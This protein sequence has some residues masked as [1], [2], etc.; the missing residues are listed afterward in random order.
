MLFDGFPREVYEAKMLDKF[1]KVSH[2]FVM[3][4]PEELIIKRLSSRYECYCGMTYNLT[5]KKPRHDLM[6]DKCGRKLY[7]REDDKPGLIRKRINIYKRETLPVVLH[8]KK[9]SKT[10]VIGINGAREIRDVFND[11][12]KVLE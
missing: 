8:Y 12:K 10:K 5:S 9:N 1:I 2:V 3:K 7:R 6:C 11:V 4:V